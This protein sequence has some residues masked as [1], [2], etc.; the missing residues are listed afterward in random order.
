[1]PVRVEIP[2]DR[3]KEFFCNELPRR[4]VFDMMNASGYP[5]VDY[6]VR[7][8]A[9]LNVHGHLVEVHYGW[10]SFRNEAEAVQFKLSHL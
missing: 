1:M 9:K 7:F 2:V 8:Q 10:I 3:V 4:E 5:A 6:H